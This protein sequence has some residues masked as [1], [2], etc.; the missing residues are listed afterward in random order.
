MGK[1]SKNSNKNLNKI[2]DHNI[3]GI[4]KVSSIKT[5]KCSYHKVGMC[6]LGKDCN[7]LHNFLP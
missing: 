5:I 1:K 4:P 2:Y 7:Y 3:G 6:N